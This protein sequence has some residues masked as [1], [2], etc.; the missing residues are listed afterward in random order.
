MTPR[1]LS[2][3][4]LAL[5]IATAAVG[6]PSAVAN[7]DTTVLRATLPNG[8]RVVVVRD[9]LA[10]VVT[11]EINYL[12]GSNEAP[13]GFPGTAHAEEHMMF[14][15]SAGLSADQLANISASM[16]GDNDADTMQSVTQYFFTVPAENLDLALRIEALRMK[17]ALNTQALWNEE[18]GAIE[19]E[20]SRDLSNPSYVFYSR[21]LKR[22]FTGTPYAH[23]A[24]GTRPSFEKTTGA[25]LKQFHDRWYVPN[26]AVL[27]IAGDVDPRQAL[28]KVRAEFGGIPAKPLP[29]RPVIR[30]Q[31]VQPTTMHLTSDLPYGLAFIAFRMPGYASSDYAATRVL[32]EVLNSSRGDLTQLQIS[33]KAL[34]AGFSQDAFTEAG[35]GFGVIA[36]PDGSDA[37]G[38]V[39]LL[40]DTLTQRIQQGMPADLVT[41]AKARALASVEYQ[42]NSVEGLA[43][44]W[45]QALAV[46]GRQSPADLAQAIQNVTVADVNRV[47]RKY[48]NF[49]QAI[50]ATL[51]PRPSG[52][53]IA[54]HGFGGKENFAPSKT[55]AVKLPDWA[56]ASLSKLVVPPSAVHPT[57]TVLPNGLKLIVQ[58]EAV[59]D[60]VNVYGRIK[61]NSDL[62]AGP[63]K[64]GVQGLLNS[65]FDYGTTTL[66]RD[67][68]QKALD[69]IAAD[70]SAGSA[71]SLNV[72]SSHFE[73]GLQ[74]LADNELHPALPAAA[75]KV[76]QKETADSLA[77]ELLT[78]D[79]LTDRA[80]DRALLPKDDPDLRQATPKTVNALTLADVKTYYQDAYRP[81]ETTIVVIGNVKPDEAKTLVSKYFGGWQAAGPKPETLLPPVPPNAA[82]SVAVPDASRTQVKTTLAEMLELNRY[83]PDYYALQLGNR[84]LGGGFYATRLYRD[85]REKT[86]LVY[87]VG[88]SFDVG[89]TRA[90]YEVNYGCDPQNVSKARTLVLA[91]LKAMQTDLVSPDELH[92]A[93]AMAMRAIPLSESSEGSIAGGLL[94]RAVEGL[95][96]DEP[97]RAAKRYL[98]LNAQQVRTAFDKWVDLGRFVQVTE[99]PT[100][101]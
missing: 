17:D 48:L 31:P 51:A 91:D 41:A 98:A 21:L 40:R 58:P 33:G 10:P 94:G 38:M 64:E 88:T 60:T 66:D 71:F 61:T 90:E 84:V 68:F 65:L 45:S 63:G 13:E 78:P 19:Q 23:D 89:K 6:A 18:R 42:K 14:R 37:N 87:Y 67:A 8:L 12:V 5:A 34:G 1:R 15:G 85:L 26:N 77:G 16:G 43:M 4:L 82:R 92:Q 27:V 97:T 7:P 39:K 44:A 76:E 72:L 25:M 86:G 46:E 99:G 52:K 30:L 83:N 81:D 75:F 54:S 93:K 55:Q 62:E 22:M 101:R 11:T 79:Y 28:A 95:P 69:D 36:Y 96:L 53:P 74:L 2:K 9:P 70:E 24:L 100:P 50:V 20:V 80:L 47:A 56:Q 29:Q 32:A 57:V 73:R 59:S 49:N 3:G 35:L